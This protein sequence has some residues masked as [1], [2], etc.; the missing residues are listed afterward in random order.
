MR[1]AAAARN[2]TGAAAALRGLRQAVIGNN[3]RKSKAAHNWPH[4][5]K[6]RPPGPPRLRPASH[7]ERQDCQR[8]AHAAA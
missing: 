8:F 5:K 4:K 6:Q 1:Q 2:K 3:A 7:A